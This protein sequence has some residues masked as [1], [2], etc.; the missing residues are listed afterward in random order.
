[1]LLLDLSSSRNRPDQD[2]KLRRNAEVE[3]EKNPSGVFSRLKLGKKH[4]EKYNY[5]YIWKKCKEII[6]SGLLVG[7]KQNLIL[8]FLGFSQWAQFV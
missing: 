1:M 2:G 3:G 7:L 6:V 8:I 5:N 4:N